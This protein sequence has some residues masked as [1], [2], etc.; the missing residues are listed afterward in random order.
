MTEETQDTPELKK[1]ISYALFG[2]NKE[3]QENCFDFYS[4]L[5]SML[6]NI[7]LNRLIYPDWEMVVETDFETYEAYKDLFERLPIT[8]KPNDPEP[9]TKAM[10]W[11]L[12]SVFLY[13]E[14][15]HV[16]CRDLDSPPTYREAQAVQDWILSD[17]GCH[18]ITDSISHTI[19]LMGGMI[20]FRP[21]YF[22]MLTGYQNWVDLFENVSSIN[23]S[24]K[25]ADQTFL[26]KYLYPKFANPNSP[27][28]TQ[29]YVLG[30]GNTW[31]PGFKNHI[32]DIEVPGVSPELKESNE[33]CGHIG[34]AG[35]WPGPMFKLLQKYQDRFVDILE[36][37]KQFPEV[38][39]W[40]KDGIFK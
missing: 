39:Y 5:R 22:P 24:K 13:E 28:I 31:L 17:Q 9:L 32:P 18:A 40:V 36:V 38:A 35:Y 30:H 11:R 12:K 34:A 26:N 15:S 27:H 19:P 3:R 20:G 37:E 29:H 7:R 21:Q 33:I 10:L 23:F 6:L 4:Y 14:Y 1:A 16:I 8:I 2:A 25:G